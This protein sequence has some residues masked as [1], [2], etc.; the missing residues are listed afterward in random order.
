MAPSR[1]PVVRAFRELK[2][3][4]VFPAVGAYIVLAALLIELSGAIFDA[5]LL[6]DWSSRLF[7][8]IMILG[9]PVV[10][11]L[12]WFFDL[13]SSGL[14]RT[15]DRDTEPAAGQAGG[16][17]RDLGAALQRS[18]AVPVPEG[19]SPRRKPAALQ[20]EA[21]AEGEAPDPERVREAALGHMRH[22]LRTPI[23]GIIGYAEMV[24]EDLGEGPLVA[25]LERIRKAGRQLLDRVDTV[26][27]PGS[28]AGDSPEELDALATQ[29][30]LDLRTPIN[31]VVGYA[32]LVTETC[33]EEGRHQLLP[34]LERILISARRLLALSEDIV[35]V[36]TLRPEAS[37]PE[38][39]TA[40]S[41]LTREVLSRIRPVESTGVRPD[42]EGRLLVVDDNETNRDL[43]SRQ[44]ARQGYVVATATNGAEGFERLE[45][46]DFDLILL[47]VIMPEMNGVE[48]L[49][50][51]QED[52]RWAAIPVI[53]LSSL[54]EVDSAVRCIEMGA[55]D[56]V[57]KPVQATLLE[58]RIAAALELREL[59]RREGLYRK[60][61]EA[62]GALIGRLLYGA[63]PATVRERVAEG[64][65]EIVEPYPEVTVVR[66]L[67]PAALRPNASEAGRVSELSGLLT[68]IEAVAESEDADVCLWR[69]DGF[70]VLMASNGDHAA[71]A[72]R[73][74]LAA[75][76][77][78]GEWAVSF[79][80][81]T[82]PAVGGVLGR[83]RPRFEVWGDAVETAQAVVRLAAAG[84]VLMTPATELELR[85][86]HV[87]EPRGV[88]EVGGRQMRLHA[89]VGRADDGFAKDG[90]A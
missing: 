4:R 32:E 10:A 75:R 8:V 59:R 89:L 68:R 35:G 46:D 7:T 54:D 21:D 60:R 5:L 2:R 9:L 71:R 31:A 15:D 72:A 16:R 28:L 42:G 70:V 73:F 25:D 53:M 58:A 33:Q 82:G 62:D 19:R 77:A 76:D 39:L 18:R 29:V 36:A 43:L 38:G 22:E 81:H 88:Q 80:L 66:G 57:S 79:G 67:V 14:H 3:R 49:A 40:S 51:L 69:S 84:E 90:A 11:V 17:D 55:L 87:L 6:P 30:R 13:S 37:G 65:L 85:G 45:Q 27:R 64:V 83:D 52:E 20:V 86:G 41:E 47:D 61:V 23:N 74:V 56:Y 48:M 63:V 1:S 34:D 24:L 12:S 26:L 78:F 50:R 44:L